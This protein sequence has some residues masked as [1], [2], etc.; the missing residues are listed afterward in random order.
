MKSVSEQD[1][2][3][4]LV[5]LRSGAD[6]ETLVS[7][8]T[9]GDLL[10]QL[11]VAPETRLRYDFPYDKKMPANL[12]MR[13]NAYLQSP[14]YDP[15]SV[16]PSSGPL[17]IPLHADTSG[18]QNTS[19]EIIYLRPFHAAEVVDTRLADLDISAW[20]TVCDNNELMRS[21]L[22]RWLQCEYHFTAA[23]QIDLF[24]EDLMAVREDYCSSLLVNIMLGYAC[25]RFFPHCVDRT[26]DVLLGLLP[27][28][29][30]PCRVLEPPHFNIPIPRGSKTF[31]G[32]RLT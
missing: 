19:V 2:N 20:T 24:L 26:P 22:R 14:I 29:L 30:P 21:L 28:A 25:V 17:S 27:S 7:H 23:F 1:A 16:Y 13:D 18:E 9:N 6:I 15:E 32:A 3:D 4:I 12:L 10:L 31:V 5:R 11:S 8:V